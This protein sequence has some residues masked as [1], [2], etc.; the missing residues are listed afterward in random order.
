MQRTA[1]TGERAGRPATA[2]DSTGMTE[3]VC[4]RLAPGESALYRALRLDSLRRDP[5]CFGVT[6]D[7]EAQ[8]PTLAFEQAIEAGAREQFVVGASS[9]A[10]LVGIAAFARRG[11]RKTMHR[12]DISQVYV[13]PDRR[14][15]AAGSR[16]LR[17]TLQLAFD[18]PGLEQV[19]LSVVSTNAAALRLYEN[20][21]FRRYGLQ[22]NY[23]KVGARRWH[24]ILMQL[25]RDHHVARD[26]PR[27]TPRSPPDA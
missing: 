18:L 7:E 13:D 9:G 23:F 17:E 4:R 8:V 14:G 24:M 16:L 15:N 11:R 22:E 19:E 1:A 20:L 5:D 25:T 6:Y 27:P 10:R 2:R 21:S 12:G 3:L 26:R